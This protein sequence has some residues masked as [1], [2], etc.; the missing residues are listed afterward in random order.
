M[1]ELT[2]R[3]PSWV[4]INRYGNTELRS[5]L[6]LLHLVLSSIHVKLSFKV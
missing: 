3:E 4:A 5:G 2:S 1:T 6:K